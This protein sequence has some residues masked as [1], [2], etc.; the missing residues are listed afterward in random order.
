MATLKDIKIRMGSIKNTQHI[1][2]AMKMVAAS[3]MKRAED[4][5]SSASPYKEKLSALVSNLSAGIDESSHPLMEKRVG[6][7]ALVLLITSDKGLCGGL[8]SNLCKALSKSFMKKDNEFKEVEIIAFGKKGYEFFKHRNTDIADTIKDHKESELAVLLENKV[9]ELIEDYM[10]GKY[11]YLF[12]AYNHFK[13]VITQEIKIQQVLP[14]KPPENEEKSDI[15]LEFIFEPD[16]N[17]LLSGILPQYVEN[18]AFTALL[19][20]LACEHASR[21]T[22]MDAATKNASE[23]LSALQLKYNRARQAMITTEL[24]EIISG[25]ESI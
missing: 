4:K 7:K 17:E 15:N 12:L 18:Q 8:N 3:K 22:A 11:N 2:K 21:M 1:T 16:K 25:A 5:I 24:I 14:I 19:D 20:S 6:G 9:K 13:N 10:E 23:M